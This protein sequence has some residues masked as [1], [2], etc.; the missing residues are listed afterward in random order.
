MIKQNDHEMLKEILKTVTNISEDL[1]LLQTS[2]RR[3]KTNQRR[4]KSN[5]RRRKTDQRRCKTSEK[6][7]KRI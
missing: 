6:R 7:R 3:R 1:K 5:Q 4:R 2:E